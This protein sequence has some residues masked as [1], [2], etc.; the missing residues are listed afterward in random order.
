VRRPSGGT[1]SQCLSLLGR[2]SNVAGL[3]FTGNQAYESPIYART[4][5]FAVNVGAG[6]GGLV[7]GPVGAGVLTLGYLGYT[8]TKWCCGEKS[9]GFCGSFNYMTNTPYEQILNDLS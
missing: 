3:A 8:G 2:A 7:L 4:L 6:A 1:I 5:D 9:G